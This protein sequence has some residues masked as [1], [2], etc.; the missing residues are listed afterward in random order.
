VSP[1]TEGSPLLSQLRV[2]VVARS[3]DSSG[4][5][6]GGEHPPLEAATKQRLLKNWKMYVCC[7]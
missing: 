2:A 7:S 1:G 6:E 3:G 4:N 5:S